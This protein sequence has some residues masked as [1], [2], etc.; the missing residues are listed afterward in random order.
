MP[1][2]WGRWHTRF[3]EY[4]G[5]GVVN[6]WART[7][8]PTFSF[9]NATSHNTWEAKESIRIPNLKNHFEFISLCVLRSALY[10]R[11]A[12]KNHSEFR[13]P[14]S[15]FKETIPNS[16]FKNSF[17]IF[18]TLSSPSTSHTFLYSWRSLRFYYIIRRRLPRRGWKRRELRKDVAFFVLFFQKSLFFSFLWDICSIPAVLKII[19]MIDKSVILV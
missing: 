12:L 4:D 14:N 1:S 6:V 5:W 18:I 10:L 7:L 16:E 19:Y 15:E 13:I 8:P 11:S 17:R 9:E 2:P 3:I